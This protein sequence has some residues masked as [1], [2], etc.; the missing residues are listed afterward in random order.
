MSYCVYCHVNKHNNKR[1]VGITK[2]NPERRWNNGRGYVNSPHF[3]AAIKK[4][5]WEEF[6][7]EILFT[8]LSKKE[9]EEKEIYLIAKWNLQNKSKGYNVCAGGNVNII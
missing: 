1:Y 2:Q 7:H 9:A 3:Y 5:G 4:Y 6:T 8:N